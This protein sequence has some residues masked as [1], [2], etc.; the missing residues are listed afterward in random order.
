[1]VN[2]FEN[3]RNTRYSLMVYEIRT[4]LSY[5]LILRYLIVFIFILLHFILYKSLNYGIRELL[6]V[7]LKTNLILCFQKFMKNELNFH[8]AI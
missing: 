6:R 3:G 5:I 8:I 1:M 2:G 4:D 7:H